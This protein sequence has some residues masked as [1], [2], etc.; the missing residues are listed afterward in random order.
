MSADQ[1]PAV[2]FFDKLK[3]PFW[4]VA[5]SGPPIIV[6]LFGGYI[7]VET[8]QAPPGLVAEAAALGLLFLAVFL[9]R[10]F[11]GNFPVESPQKMKWI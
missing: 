1:V 4:V 11:F 10:K 8:Q 7:A 6:S 5:T 3:L 2:P 9:N